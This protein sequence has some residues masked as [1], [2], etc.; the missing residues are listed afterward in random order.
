[1]LIGV[2]AMFNALAMVD[3]ETLSSYDVG[4]LRLAVTAGAKSSPHLMST[5]E[6]RYGLT[7]CEVYGTTEAIASTFGDIHNRRLGTVG[8]PV[9]EVKLLDDAGNEV[10]VGETGEFVCRSPEL[11]QG[12]YNAP[13]L[14]AK[15]L[16][17]GWFHSGDLVRMDKDGYIEYVE[18][19]SFII[20]TSGGTKIPPTDVEDTLLACP[21]IAEAAYVGVED[22]SGNQTPTLFVVPRQGANL[23]RAGIRRYC[24]EHL[25]DYK[26]PRR[27]ELIEEIPK[28]GSGKIDRR[29]LK[30][31]RGT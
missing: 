17:D 23:T 10:A 30:M 28:T 18:K 9:Q 31:H 8:K 27:I 24:A 26:M 20:V 21:G 25:A 15:V 16:R 2:P 12:Y 13:E 6:Q 1:M 7:L 19:K 11:M 14:T 22:A 29:A 5:L 3:D 4:P